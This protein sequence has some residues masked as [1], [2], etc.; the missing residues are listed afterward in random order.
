MG[1]ID[2]LRQDLKTAMRARDE[3]RKS[4]IRMVLTSVQLAEVE[5][6]LLSDADVM[7]LIQGEVRRREEALEMMK[8]AERDDLVADETLEIDLLRAYLPQQL[9]VEQIAEIARK[10]MI[11]VDATAPSDFGNV[12][13]VMMPQVKGRADGRIVNEVVRN[14]LNELRAAS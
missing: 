11:E 8:Q 5:K 14:L 3:H 12:M 13:K 1:L 4:V 9:S 10:V 6:G 7:H 2:Q